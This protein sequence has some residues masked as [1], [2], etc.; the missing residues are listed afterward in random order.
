MVIAEEKP[1]VKTH[2][3]AKSAILEALSEQD[4]VV[5]MLAY[6]YAQ[7]FVEI[8]EDVTK[9]WITTQQQTA[10][11]QAAY[12][13]GYEEALAKIKEKVEYPLGRNDYQE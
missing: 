11:L 4:D 8:G 12:N 9:K 10:L 5:L 2:S 1:K 6:S 13:K 7:N 3:L